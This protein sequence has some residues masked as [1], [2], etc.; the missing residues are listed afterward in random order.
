L[1]ARFSPSDGDQ[2]SPDSYPMQ[3]E[4]LNG[5]TLDMKAQIAAPLKTR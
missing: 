2:G 1:Y 4:I 3:H 5:L